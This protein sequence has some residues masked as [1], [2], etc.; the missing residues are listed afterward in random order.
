LSTIE[1][2]CEFYWNIL[3]GREPLPVDN[4]VLGLMESAT[5]IHTRACE[6]Q[7][8]IQT[9]EYKGTIPKGS[10]LYKFRTGPLRALIAGAERAVDLG[11]RRVTVWS[12]EQEQTRSGV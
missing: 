4:G 12:N 5:A 3:T 1:E 10:L 9:G 8:L 2:E 6:L 11:S 7:A